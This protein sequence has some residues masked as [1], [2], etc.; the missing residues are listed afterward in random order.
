M[1]PGAAASAAGATAR[2]H[3]STPSGVEAHRE[4]KAAEV[5]LSLLLVVN[6]I[7]DGAE[8][9]ADKEKHAD[10]CLK[11]VRAPLSSPYRIRIL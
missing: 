2:G 6:G 3:S 1:E 11:K 5:A 4:G 8:A 10:A 7:D 9:R